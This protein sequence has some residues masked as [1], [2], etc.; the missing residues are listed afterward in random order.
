MTSSVQ[1]AR[2]ALG[3]RLRELRRAAGMS[4]RQL[5]ELAGWHESKISKLEYGK[6]PPSEADLRAY[7]EFLDEEEQLPDLLA[8]LR[9]IDNAYV[10]WRRV[11]SAG[12]RRGQHALT[13][14]AEQAQIM[15]V[16]QPY[17]IPGLLQTAGYAEA[18]LRQAIDFY[19]IP[20][21]LD[22]GVSKRLER[23][24]IL[25]RRDHRFHF[26]IGEQALFTRVAGNEVM[27]GQLDRLLT[28][29]G[30]PRVGIGIVPTG[31]YCPAPAMNFVMYDRRMVTVEGI[32]AE[33]KVTQS[34]EIQIYSRAFDVLARQSLT[35][36]PARGLI[37]SALA[38]WD[39]RPSTAP[40]P[41]P[42]R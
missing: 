26:L 4:G 30:L 11:L 17:V 16:F 39:T 13:R 23:Q 41:R 8:T 37:K 34:R 25:Y 24:Q 27:I 18:I 7:C 36:E 33:L 22:E 38:G 15:R 21:D 12:T 40:A 42:A 6:R 1:E 19:Q 14:L 28:L 31:A 35:G 9:N 3:Q 10:E 29:M 20:N 32:A 2:E 5:A